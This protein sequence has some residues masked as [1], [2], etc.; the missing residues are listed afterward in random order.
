MHNKALMVFLSFVAVP[1]VALDRAASAAPAPKTHGET[2]ARLACAMANAAAVPRIVRTELAG[3]PALM[4]IPRTVS[5]PPIVLWHGFGPPETQSALMEL[6]LLD[7]VPAVKVYLGL[8]M[9]GARAPI[10]R[11][12][13]AKRQA[14]DLA[15]GIFEPIVMGAARELPPVVAALRRMGCM[16]PGRGIRLFGFSAGGAAALYALAE[17]DVW[18]ESA[19]V[20]NAS[21]GLSASVASYERATGRS[22]DWTPA[23][24]ALARQSDAEGRAADIG[25][26]ARAPALLILQGANDAMIT[27]ESARNLHRALVPH[28]AASQRQRSLRLEIIEGMPHSVQQPD[29][30]ARVQGLV[31]SWFSQHGAK[32]RAK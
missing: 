32:G 6:L 12:A 22:Y 10:D 19:V 4:R 8:P 31:S 14:E 3:V 24:R 26:G 25:G 30:V 23:S 28:Y 27:T 2:S 13:L 9:F 7:D 20:L 1:A 11:D 18:V 16:K 17:R 5:G 29:D 15:T 21:T